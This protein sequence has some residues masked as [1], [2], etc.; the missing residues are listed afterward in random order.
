M[1]RR[2]DPIAQSVH[3]RLLRI[4]ADRREDFNGLLARYGIERLLYRL[5]RTRHGKRFVLK[6][7]T[8]FLIW[9]DRPHRPT[10]DLDLL[11]SGRI[12]ESSLRAV[13]AEVC[14]ARVKPDGLA[15]DPDAVVVRAIRENQVHRVLRVKILGRLGNARMSVQIDVGMG[16]V[17]TPSPVKID[18]PT[19]L[20]LPAPHLMAYPKET[21]A[22]EK[23]EAMIRLGSRNSRTKDPFDL[24]KM[25][26]HFEFDGY[27]LAEAIRQ[28]FERRQTLLVAE[29]TCF[30][31]LYVQDPTK[32]FQWS[33]FLRRNRLSDAPE[34]FPR[35][36]ERLRAFLQPVI[37]ALVDGKS[38]DRAWSPGGPWRY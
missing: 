13:F 3:D 20:D 11:G 8:L 24:W 19:L 34:D 29:P 30:S 7:A 6:G 16:D 31:E 17:I 26:G 18:F 35:V 2:I 25:S 28:T 23:L 21:V 37:S 5:T 10:R 27:T 14:T 32:Q 36:M 4:A 15:F 22:A 1:N 33:A 38:Y 12:T 9:F